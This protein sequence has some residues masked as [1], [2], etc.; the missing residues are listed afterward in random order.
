MEHL[1]AAKLDEFMEFYRTFYVPQNATLSIAGDLDIAKTK[2]LVE[3]YFGSIPKGKREIPRPK[4]VEPALGK[5]IRDTVFDKIQ[6][7][8]VVQAYRIPA[9]GTPDY[10]ALQVLTTLLSG[11][12]SSRYNRSIVYEQQKAVAT[13]A[14]PFPL[15]DP[16]VF[17]ALGIC[18]QET[19]PAELEKAMDA[20]ADRVKKEPITEAEKNKVINQIETSFIEQNQQVAGIAENLANYHVYYGDA[21]LINTEMERYRAVTAADVLRVANQYLVKENRVVLYYLPQ[22]SN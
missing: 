1:N 2:V 11:G 18:N 9:Q 20:E 22:A 7:P 15:E 12:G 16:G 13:F 19:G 3:K 21:N 6:L 4:V 10:Y 14:F 5:E 8:A 17:I